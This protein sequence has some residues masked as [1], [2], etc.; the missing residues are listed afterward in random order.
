MFDGGGLELRITKDSTKQWLFKY[1]KPLTKNRTNISFGA[2]PTTS[3]ANARLKRQAAKELLAQDIDLYV[4][5]K[6]QELAGKKNAV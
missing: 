1:Y 4:H 2:Y 3:L 6:E 5:K